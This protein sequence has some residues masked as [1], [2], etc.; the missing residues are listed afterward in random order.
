MNHTL[1]VS[2]S[3]QV[4]IRVGQIAVVHIASLSALEMLGFVSPTLSEW[5][6]KGTSLIGGAATVQAASH[7]LVT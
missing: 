4:A 1:G 5:L 7:A 2:G 3:S 6:N